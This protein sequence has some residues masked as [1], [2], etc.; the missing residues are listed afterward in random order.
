[1]LKALP[2]PLLHEHLTSLFLEVLRNATTVSQA[3]QVLPPSGVLRDDVAASF[4]LAE[5]EAGHAW[6]ALRAIGLTH[7]QDDAVGAVVETARTV[8]RTTKG[9]W[10]AARAGTLFTQTLTDRILMGE[11]GANDSDHQRVV[12]AIAVAIEWDVDPDG[13]VERIQQSLPH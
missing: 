13:V 3:A 6:D 7:D 4:Q 11:L 8:L 12:M 9:E 2:S 1:V 5:A 10:D